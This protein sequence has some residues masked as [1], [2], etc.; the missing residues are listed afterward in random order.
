M[1]LHAPSTSRARNRSRRRRREVTTG[2]CGWGPEVDTKLRITDV[3]ASTIVERIS[4]RAAFAKI[5]LNS[6]AL[7]ERSLNFLAVVS[8]SVSSILRWSASKSPFW[9]RSHAARTASRR[10]LLAAA[11]WNIEAGG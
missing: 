10:H 3:I 9:A 2:S 4:F 6:I 5:V 7:K 1:V 8:T 11:A